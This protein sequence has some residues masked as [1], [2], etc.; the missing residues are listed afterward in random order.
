MEAVQKGVH[1]GGAEAVVHPAAVATGLWDQ[2]EEK[3]AICGNDN[4]SRTGVAY[5]KV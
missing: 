2:D 4:P 1:S 3:T 5:R